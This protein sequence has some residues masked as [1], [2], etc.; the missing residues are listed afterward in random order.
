MNNDFQTIHAVGI[1]MEPLTAKIVI[2]GIIIL[3]AVMM[4]EVNVDFG[5]MLKKRKLGMAK[6]Y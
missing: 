1:G 4:T 2:G 3:T 5:G 6:R